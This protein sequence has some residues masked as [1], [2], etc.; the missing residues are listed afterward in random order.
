MDNGKIHMVPTSK[1]L[2]PPLPQTNP[3]RSCIFT[4]L[5]KFGPVLLLNTLSYN[6]VCFEALYRALE[7]YVRSGD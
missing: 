1:S 7:G 3:A 4:K 2:T 5:Q 6:V